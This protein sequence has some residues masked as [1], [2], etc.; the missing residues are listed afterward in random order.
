MGIRIIGLKYIGS[1]GIGRYLFGFILI[2]LSNVALSDSLDCDKLINMTESESGDL[3]IKLRAKPYPEIAGGLAS[4][5]IFNTNINHSSTKTYRLLMSKCNAISKKY[6]ILNKY[7]A[8]KEWH[9]YLIQ[10]YGEGD[11]VICVNGV[12]QPDFDDDGCIDKY[13][14]SQPNTVKVILNG[15]ISI[16]STPS[17][18]YEFQNSGQILEGDFNGDK[19]TDLAHVVTKNVD[20][21]W[22]VHI[23]FSDPD[24]P[25]SFKK[26][27]R[28]DFRNKRTPN[29]DATTGVWNANDFDG[30]GLTDLVHDSKRGNGLRY[31]KSIGNGEFAERP[32]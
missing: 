2:G 22:Y 16:S 24:N 25:G 9:D 7:E 30:D 3:Y 8:S 4:N 27:P 20:D 17:L 10:Y 11:E 14:F 32:R 18:E 13:E 21:P 1:V 29:Y 23:H 26:P 28:Y 6:N 5:T 15:K 19:L 12:G 31:W